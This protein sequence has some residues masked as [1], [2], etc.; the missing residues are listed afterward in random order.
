MAPRTARLGSVSSMG[1]AGRRLGRTPSITFVVGLLASMVTIVFAPPAAAT[2]IPDCATQTYTSS[3]TCIVP[4]GSEF[5]FIE[6]AGAKGGNGA[7]VGNNLGGAGGAG[8]K[9]S[10]TYAVTPG[11]TL[12]ITIG[13][14]GA[15][16]TTRLG[17]AGGTQG[18]AAGGAGSVTNGRGGGGGGGL[19]QVVNATTSTDLITAGG[20]GG[21][22]GGGNNLCGVG[23]AQQLG[24][25]GGADGGDGVSGDGAGG[26]GGSLAV[27]GGG[28]PAVGGNGAGGGGG[29]GAGCLGGAGGGG[30]G[31]NGSGGG[32][33]AGSSCGGITHV[34]TNALAGSVRLGTGADLSVAQTDSAD[35]AFTGANLDYTVTVANA[36]PNPAA[37]VTVTDTLPSGTTFVGAVPADGGD[38]CDAP[39][40]GQVVC[41]LGS[42][43]SGDTDSFVLTV[44]PLKTGE[45]ANVVSATSTVPDP[46]TPNNDFELTEITPPACTNTFTSGTDNITGTSGADVLCGGDGNDS[47]TG[48]GGNDILVGGAGT[49]TM[50]GGRGDDHLDGGAGLDTA[51]FYDSGVASGV[52]VSLVTATTS[53]NATLGTDTL[54][55]S[56]FGVSRT[57]RVEG[58]P[59][60]DVITGDGQANTL[61]GRG[62]NDQLIGNGGVDTLVGSVGNDDLQGGSGSD[63]LQPGPGNDTVDGGTS[64]DQLRFND[65]PL[66]AGGV[67]A[68]LSGGGVG[69][70]ATGGSGSDSLVNLESVSGT[71]SGDTFTVQI[72]GIVSNVEGHGGA[73]TLDTQDA[74]AEADLIGCGVA[75]GA[76]D[77]VTKDGVDTTT[78]CP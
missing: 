73:D 66:A 52:V 65:T 72:P 36:G 18:G 46:T 21:G 11:D 56:G 67:V 44:V 6:A 37:S 74:G 41:H 19:S 32:G 40:G 47:L 7:G 60:D 51:T 39:A 48:L 31:T 10:G 20:G 76:V 5:M 15:N 29:G 1:S 77:N 43:G 16:T 59:F 42:I 71:P 13:G 49:D 57:E 69:T 3:T 27:A 55:V 33:G 64:R 68:T 14:V 78:N 58:S 17:G 23:C 34:G 53:A 50:A 35:P 28:D 2:P 63:V 62:G 25:L 24:G 9:W 54:A 70:L 75:D 30:G 38:T 61:S 45:I 22:G 12:T 26:A 4:A 8:A